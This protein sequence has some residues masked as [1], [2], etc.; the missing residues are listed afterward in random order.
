M[1]EEK[2]EVKNEVKTKK[3][4]IGKIINVLLWI[5][6]LGWMAIVLLDF[7]AVNKQEEPRFCISQGETK[8]SD[9]YV[10]WCTGLGYKVYEYKRKCFDAIEFGPFWTKDRSINEETCK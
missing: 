9:G 5:L 6:V 8:Y 4:I 3:S 10:K 7:F 1:E 2:N